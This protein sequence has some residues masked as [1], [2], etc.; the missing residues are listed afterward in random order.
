M[1]L[2]QVNLSAW[3]IRLTPWNIPHHYCGFKVDRLEQ[4]PTARNMVPLNP[5]ELAIS[6]GPSY[7]AV[8][9]FLLFRDL[10]AL[11]FD[12]LYCLG[13]LSGRVASWASC[14]PSSTPPFMDCLGELSGGAASWASCLPFSSPPLS[15][16]SPSSGRVPKV[17][18]VL[19]LPRLLALFPRTLRP[20]SIVNFFFSL[21]LRLLA[22]R[23]IRARL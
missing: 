7:E 19:P 22:I 18:P 23:Y 9:L 16:P 4:Q 20:L 13:M 5:E 12:A 11:D 1:R 2:I 17:P 6:A 10:L 14:V 15:P 8:A 21:T 3:E